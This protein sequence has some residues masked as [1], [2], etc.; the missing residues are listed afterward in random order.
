MPSN[1]SCDGSTIVHCPSNYL[2]DVHGVLLQIMLLKGI[3]EENGIDFA[4]I[5]SSAEAALSEDSSAEYD[6]DDGDEDEEE[7]EEEEEGQEGVAA[8]SS[9]AQGE[10]QSP[11]KARGELS[12]CM[13]R[14]LSMRSKAIYMPALN[15]FGVQTVT[16]EQHD[17]QGKIHVLSI[18]SGIL[19]DKNY[20]LCEGM[21]MHLR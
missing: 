17:V 14:F 18:F 11:G 21:L 19:P 6:D 10:A 1:S 4:A 15:S 8:V 20:P 12:S 3:L 16:Q 9:T 13:S 7:E 5:L 2:P